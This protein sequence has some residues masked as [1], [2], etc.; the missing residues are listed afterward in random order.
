LQ[1]KL[2]N[3]PQY[4]EHAMLEDVCRGFDKVELFLSAEAVLVNTP[5]RGHAVIED[6]RIMAASED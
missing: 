6:V 5:D 3:T 1:A 4:E 2:V